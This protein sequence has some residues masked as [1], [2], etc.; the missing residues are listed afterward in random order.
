L[1]RKS[2]RL[3]RTKIKRFLLQKY[4]VRVKVLGFRPRC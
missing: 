4:E 3:T 2:D 1:A